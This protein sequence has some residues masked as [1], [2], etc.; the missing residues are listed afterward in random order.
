VENIEK[1]EI[2]KI[3]KIRN[4]FDVAHSKLDMVFER[5]YVELCKKIAREVLLK[6]LKYK[7]HARKKL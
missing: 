4:D 1:K 3:V 7:S 2:G 6:Y 5:E